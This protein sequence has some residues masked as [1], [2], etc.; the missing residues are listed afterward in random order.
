MVSLLTCFI[1]FIL[2]VLAMGV[3]TRI[4]IDK[5]S[6]LVPI[7][8]GMDEIIKHIRSRGVRAS[9]YLVKKWLDSG[10]LPVRHEL[11]RYFTTAFVL[12]GWL[13]KNRKKLEKL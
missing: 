8:F 12:N 2:V 11:D 13:H 3:T 4:L 5:Q 6:K 9:S 7:I 10:E 1:A